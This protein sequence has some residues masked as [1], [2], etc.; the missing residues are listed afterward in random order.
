METCSADFKLAKCF[1]TSF[2]PENDS[3]NDT[4]IAQKF[5][6]LLPIR[7]YTAVKDRHESRI[8]RRVDVLIRFDSNG[9]PSMSLT[10]I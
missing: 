5:L 2:N 1:T 3:G 4:G 9:S 7:Y 10:S 6:G 8:T